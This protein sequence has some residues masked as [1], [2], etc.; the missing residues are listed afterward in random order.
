MSSF[1]ILAALER[2]MPAPTGGA[3]GAAPQRGG[4]THPPPDTFN[5]QESIDRRERA[6]RVL[7]SWEMLAWYSANEMEV[8][9]CVCVCVLSQ[10][11]FGVL[12]FPFLC[13]GRI[14]ALGL[15][16]S[17]GGGVGL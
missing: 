8:G 14:R 1:P 2:R 4:P 9:V 5:M 16:E 17:R 11:A 10:V 12:W 3:R 15:F 13:R 6:A 7:G